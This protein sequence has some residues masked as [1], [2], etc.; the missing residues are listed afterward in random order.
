MSG[1]L[2]KRKGDEMK[3]NG[4]PLRKRKGSKR[5][6]RKRREWKSR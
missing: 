3:R 4:E 1:A 6:G 5:M 2:R